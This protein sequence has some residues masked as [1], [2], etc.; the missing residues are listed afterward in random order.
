[1]N[2]DIRQIL[3]P[4][5]NRSEDLQNSRSPALPLFYP[6]N[7][8]IGIRILHTVLYTSPMVLYSVKYHR[9]CIENSGEFV[10]QS[11]ASLVGDHFLYTHGLTVWFNNDAVIEIYNTFKTYA[12]FPLSILATSK[13][14][15]LKKR[16]VEGSAGNSEVQIPWGTFL[17]PTI[18]T[19]NIFLQAFAFL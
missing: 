9:R 19:N 18:I 11:R 7:S 5:R 12:P 2:M 4:T 8:K 14:E 17:R 16:N 6:L 13:L 15:H 10:Q 1:M 3:I